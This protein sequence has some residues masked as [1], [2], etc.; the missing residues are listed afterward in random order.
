MRNPVKRKHNTSS[1]IHLNITQKTLSRKFDQKPNMQQNLI[2]EA[3][4]NN[5]F[6]DTLLDIVLN[7]NLLTHCYT[8]WREDPRVL[9]RAN[10]MC[11]GTNTEQR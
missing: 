9:H 8:G 3:S 6:K 11:T 1:I 7:C 5:L 2:T 4:L 10:G